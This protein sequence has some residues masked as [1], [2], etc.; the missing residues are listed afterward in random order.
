MMLLLWLLVL[1]LTQSA[2]KRVEGVVD[3][4]VV[5]TKEE[6]DCKYKIKTNKNC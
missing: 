1:L 2:W 5:M 3:S 4:C 6:G